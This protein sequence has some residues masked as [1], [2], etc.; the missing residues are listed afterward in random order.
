MGK[1]DLRDKRISLSTAAHAH[2][3]EGMRAHGITR[4]VAISSLGALQGV[5]RKGI[6]RNLYLYFRRKYY[7]DMHDM[8]KMVIAAP[9]IRATV[10]R[11]PMLNNGPAET[12]FE[13][14]LDERA[15][16]RGLKLSRADLASFILDDLEKNQHAGKIVALANPPD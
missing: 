10:I 12:R 3:L 2:V 8:E 7:G 6:R 15:L 9:G 16:P 5:S 14:Q 4:L 1:L 11:A 13:L